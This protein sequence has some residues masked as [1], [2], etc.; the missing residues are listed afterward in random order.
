MTRKKFIKELMGMGISRN[1]ATAA[2]DAASRA[3]IPLIKAAGRILT[4]QRLF[5]G[6]I[7]PTKQWRKAFDQTVRIQAERTPRRIR[8]LAK[9]KHRQDG[10]RIDFAVVDE[11]ASMQVMSKADH[12]ALHR[13]TARIG[14]ILDVS[15]VAAGGYPLGGTAHE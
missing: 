12:D 1:T 10:L 11:W 4:M 5:V 8:P 14:K 3:E 2:A 6:P 13:R 9:K 15:L 7:A